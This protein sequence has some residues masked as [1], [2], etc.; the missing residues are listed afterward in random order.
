MPGPST[1]NAS[2]AAGRPAPRSTRARVGSPVRSLFARATERTTEPSA[3]VRLVTRKYMPTSM[4]VDNCRRMKDTARL[5]VHVSEPR[6]P[7]YVDTWMADSPWS[8]GLLTISGDEG[9][10]ST[11]AAGF[12]R[13]VF[14]AQRG[15][16]EVIRGGMGIL[17]A[18]RMA[19]CAS[20]G[21]VVRMLV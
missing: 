16:S 6:V 1:S 18:D 10:V 4:P 5:C 9:R 11:P 15:C 21:S 2:C 17:Q 8:A 3:F 13:R 19:R 12:W 20:V 7:Q 14:P